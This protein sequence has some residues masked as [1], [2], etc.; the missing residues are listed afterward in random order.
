MGSVQGSVKEPDPQRIVCFGEPRIR[1]V[2]PELW[3]ARHHCTPGR[4]TGR[5]LTRAVSRLST[6]A[7]LA[8]AV[9]GHPPPGQ[10]LL[11]HPGVEYSG[12]NSLSSVLHSPVSPSSAAHQLVHFFAHEPCIRFACLP[13]ECAGDGRQCVL[14]RGQ[15]SSALLA[16]PQTGDWMAISRP[17]PLPL[18]HHLF[19]P[20][21]MMRTGAPISNTYLPL[22][23]APASS[24]KRH[25]SG[26]VMK[27]RVTSGRSR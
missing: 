18:K 24:T 12:T 16:G 5:D 11:V 22:P 4:S 7:C 20:G 19:R 15:Q 10:P 26:M 2:C 27:K 9:A 25:A 17:G 23:M 1:L 8:R 13:D 21:Q 3:L 14:R 6:N